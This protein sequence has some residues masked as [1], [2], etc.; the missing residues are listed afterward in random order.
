MGSQGAPSF[1]PSL[2]VPRRGSALDERRRFAP[3][4]GDTH[5]RW[6][7]S[8]AAGD[9]ASLTV[10]DPCA[11]PPPRFRGTERRDPMRLEFCE[12]RCVLG[13][14][15]V[16]WI[17]LRCAMGIVSVTAICHLGKGISLAA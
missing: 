6:S 1:R 16:R 15:T 7:A 17:P 2:R 10:V 5:L 13:R 3:R 14:L 11:V 4:S 8:W 9:C 12:W